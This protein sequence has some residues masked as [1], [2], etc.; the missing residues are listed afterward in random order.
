MHVSNEVMLHASHA[1][2]NIW[3]IYDSVDILH[4]IITLVTLCSLQNSY[5]WMH[6]L[7]LDK[8]QNAD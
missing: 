7:F 1:F 4:E 2:L 5:K 3:K 8:Q 6:A